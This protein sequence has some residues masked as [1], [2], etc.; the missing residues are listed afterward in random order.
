[1]RGNYSSFQ[2]RFDPI[3]IRYNGKL[4]SIECTSRDIIAFRLADVM[5]ADNA[6]IIHL[7]SNQINFIHCY[8]LVGMCLCLTSDYSHNGWFCLLQHLP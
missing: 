2:I 5:H 1:M 7:F 4:V 3:F 6:H 8:N